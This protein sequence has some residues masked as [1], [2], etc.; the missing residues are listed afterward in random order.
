MKIKKE[1]KR[2]AKQLFCWCLVNGVLDENRVRHV[3]QHVV[4]AGHRDCPAILSH[5][6]RLVKLELA[7]HTA[8]IESAIPLPADVRAAVEAG[9]ASRYGP[10][11]TIAFAHRPELIGGMRIRVDSDVYDGSVR[12]GLAALEQSF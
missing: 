11:L 1:A 6:R 4:A 10:G 3:V 12:A 2:E 8:T 7:R 5:F 9:L